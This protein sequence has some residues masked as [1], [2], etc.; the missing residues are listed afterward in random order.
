[1][2]DIVKPRIAAPPVSPKPSEY[3][4]WPSRGLAVVGQ[5]RLLEMGGATYELMQCRLLRDPSTVLSVPLSRLPMSG[6]RGPADLQTINE[7]LTIFS[8]K[9]GARARRW[10]QQAQLHEAAIRQGS[11][12]SLFGALKSLIGKY[13]DKKYE[14]EPVDVG[15]R[16]IEDMPYTDRVMAFDVLDLLSEE[17]SFSTGMKGASVREEL[18]AMSLIPGYAKK[19]AFM[20]ISEPAERMPSK[21]FARMFS[22]TPQQAAKVTAEVIRVTL[23]QHRERRNYAALMP[24]G[25]EAPKKRFSRDAVQT[26][27]KAKPSAVSR[28][29]KFMS[30]VQRAVQAEGSM[31]A[32]KGLTRG[33]LNKAAEILNENELKLLSMTALRLPAHRL[34]ADAA[35]KELNL[36]IE[37]A[38]KI[39]NEAAAKL[40][41]VYPANYAYSNSA[42]LSPLP[43]PK[44]KTVIRIEKPIKPIKQPKVL[45]AAVMPPVLKASKPSEPKAV[46]PPSRPIPSKTPAQQAADGEAPFV[47]FK[48]LTKGFLNKAAETLEA[49][50]LRILSMTSMRKPEY[51]LSIDAAAREL[52]LELSDAKRLRNEAAAALRLQYPP[53]YAF[54][55]S[56]ALS[57]SKEPKEK[58]ASKPV[59]EEPVQSPGRL[60]ALFARETWFV[61]TGGI[62]RAIFNRAA[63]LLTADEFEAFSRAK[64]RDRYIEPLHQQSKERN[65]PM[66]RLVALHDNAVTKLSAAFKEEGSERLASAKILRKY[67]KPAIAAPR[68]EY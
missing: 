40:R 52:G 4:I 54:A 35:A 61:P 15:L 63:K 26:E 14:K 42:A 66:A 58:S 31:V 16:T 2:L 25:T 59:K 65:L 45:D 64:M 33:F 22:M 10:Q 39:R 36:P 49:V 8:D 27:P 53:D 68:K 51:L 24:T 3:I 12:E 34:T 67:E 17:I 30:P 19:N 11:I 50:Q 9:P 7:A 55:K 41:A 44:Q 5:N 43:E 56:L 32:G 23:P 57:P 46:T 21:D 6:V 18:V 37:E 48:G 60:T 20:Q 1:M 47:A 13:A 38:K 28:P 29:L 62:T